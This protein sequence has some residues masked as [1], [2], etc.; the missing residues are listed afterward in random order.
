VVVVVEG[1]HSPNYKIPTQTA[2]SKLKAWTAA[3]NFQFLAKK[4]AKFFPAQD[5]LEQ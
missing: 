3:T 1:M 2:G 4:L 5:S